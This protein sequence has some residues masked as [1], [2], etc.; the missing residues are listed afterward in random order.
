MR[1]DPRR[2]AVLLAISREGGVVAAADMLHISP[3]AVSQQ[4]HKLEQEV[5]LQ[6]FERTPSGTIL[7]PAGRLIATAAEKIEENIEN[8]TRALQPLTGHVT[9]TVSIGA[10]QTVLRCVFMPFLTNLEHH[11][12]GLNI[13]LTETDEN[14]GMTLLRQGS[15]DLLV[16]ERDTRHSPTP[17]GYSDISLI[18][19]PW[20]VV[21]SDNTPPIN[22]IQDLAHLRWLRIHRSVVGSEPLNRIRSEVGTLEF[23]SDAYS[24][25]ETALAYVRAG[26]GATVLPAM[27]LTGI[28]LTGLRSTPLPVL[29]TRRILLRH[30]DNDSNEAIQHA[31]NQ[32]VDWVHKNPTQWPH[33]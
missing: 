10:F 9:G 27:A 25:Y 11:F 16:I 4:V 23:A 29:G 18:D 17:K 12:P 28:D 26:R 15:L 30:P 19:E 32:L 31:I 8:L 13:E 2:L 20:A 1:I 24:T 5:G 22:S 33:S 7:T 3:S 14:V 6:L 21:T